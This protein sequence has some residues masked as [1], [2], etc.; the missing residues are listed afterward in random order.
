MSIQDTTMPDSPPVGRPAAVAKPFQFTL[1]QL[2]ILMLGSSFVL[3]LIFQWG[4]IGFVV[5]YGLACVF[6]LCWGTYWGSWQWIV[7][8][9]TML[10]FGACVGLPVV[11]GGNRHP[12]RRMQ[13]SNHLKQIGIALHNYHDVYGS[14]PP[15]YVADAN[16]KPMHSW[17][18][19]VLPFAEHKPLYDLYDFNEPWDGPNN[20]KLHDQFPPYFCC[21]SSHEKQPKGETNY[22]VVV[23]PRTMWPGEK[24]NK[25]ADLKDG[26]SNTL[27]V[28]EVHNSGIH[29]MEPRDLH[30]VQTPMTINPPRGAGISSLHAN[31]ALALFADGHTTALPNTIPADVLRAL[32][33]IDGGEKIPDF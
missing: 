7:G 10:A 3:A 16:G 24:S 33:T 13:C 23:G 12:A 32:L 21:P 1:R 6:A 15:A 9:L 18:V 19:L 11:D 28:V 5:C 2:L 27:M 25:M 22:V 20:S 17:R 8:A 26:T 14:F 29:W 4:V 31:V 30:V